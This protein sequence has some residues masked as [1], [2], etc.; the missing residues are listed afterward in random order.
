MSPAEAL[1]ALID[2]LPDLPKGPAR[3]DILTAPLEGLLFLWLAI[4]PRTRR[5]AAAHVDRRDDIAANAFIGGL[6]VSEQMMLDGAVAY[7]GAGR[8]IQGVDVD[9]AQLTQVYGARDYRVPDPDRIKELQAG[10][11]A[12][13]AACQAKP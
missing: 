7:H 9:Y 2:A 12:A 4:N 10:L 1:T 8:D 5:I 11:D 3:I 13:L 6:Y